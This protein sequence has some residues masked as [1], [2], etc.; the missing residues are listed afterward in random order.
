MVGL[1]C[2]GQVMVMKGSGRCRTFARS[3]SRS[4]LV[5][6]SG[7]ASGLEKPLRFSPWLQGHF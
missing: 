2:H 3:C 6:G 5:F 4:L 7:H 1:D